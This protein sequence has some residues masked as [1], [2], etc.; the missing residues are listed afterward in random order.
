MDKNNLIEKTIIEFFIREIKE[1]NCYLMFRSG[2]REKGN[3]AIFSNLMHSYDTPLSNSKSINELSQNLKKLTEELISQHQIKNPSN[4]Y[5]YI[6]ITISHLLH[7][8]IESNGVGMSKLCSMGE[9]IYKNVCN[10]LNYKETVDDDLST[11]ISPVQV[12]AKIFQDYINEVN[13]NGLSISFDEYWQIHKDE[14]NKWVKNHLS[15]EE[16]EQLSLNS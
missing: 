3:C 5:E 14:F 6:T 2:I 4:D 13:R 10:R 7:Y 1:N 8:F 15:D 9:E 16:I 11:M 12:K